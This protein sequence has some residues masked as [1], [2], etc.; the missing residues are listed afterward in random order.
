[1]VIG[2]GGGKRTGKKKRSIF[3]VELVIVGRLL[4]VPR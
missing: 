2:C 4:V 3:Q 1:M